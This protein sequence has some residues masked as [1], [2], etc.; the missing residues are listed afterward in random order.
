VLIGSRIVLC[1][2]STKLIVTPPDGRLGPP[3]HI[4]DEPLSPSTSSHELI[5]ASTL[6]AEAPQATTSSTAAVKASRVK[7]EIISEQGAPSHIQ[8]AHPPQ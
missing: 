1:D 3:V 6:E 8:K 4:K 2:I 7:G 5:H